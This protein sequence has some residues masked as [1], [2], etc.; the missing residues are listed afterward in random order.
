MAYTTDCHVSSAKRMNPNELVIVPMMAWALFGKKLTTK[1]T[2]T[3]P[4]STEV[5][6]MA[7]ATATEAIKKTNS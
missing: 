2:A 7:K 1:L 5:W 3:W 6:A 4:F